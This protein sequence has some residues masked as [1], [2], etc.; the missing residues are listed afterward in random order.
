MEKYK[1]MCVLACISNQFPTIA[2]P[3]P[4]LSFHLAKTPIP[5]KMLTVSK[6]C[7]LNRES[8]SNRKNKITFTIF[9]SYTKQYSK[10]ALMELRETKPR[11]TQSIKAKIELIQITTLNFLFFSF[12]NNFLI[13]QL[14]TIPFLKAPIKFP[15]FTLVRDSVVEI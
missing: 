14:W 4:A 8:T 1:F 11:Y 7:A 10:V 15:Q 12:P 2:D 5:I 13:S 3:R 9:S 6:I